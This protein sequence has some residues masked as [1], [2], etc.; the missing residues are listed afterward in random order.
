MTLRHRDELIVIERVPGETCNVCGD[1]L[2][3]PGTNRKIDRLLEHRAET[4]PR[5][6]ML[7]YDY[8]R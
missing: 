6:S 7:L 4:E 5:K 8:A 2:F 3:A 1:Q